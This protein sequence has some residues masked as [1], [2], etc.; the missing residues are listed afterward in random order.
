MK[1]TTVIILILV[2]LISCQGNSTSDKSEKT[3]VLAH[4]DTCVFSSTSWQVTDSI[5]WD[6]WDLWHVRDSMLT[7]ML[8]HHV[9]KGMTKEQII[10]ILGVPDP[11]PSTLARFSESLEVGS[12]S[13]FDNPY[14]DTILKL[15]KDTAI[16]MLAYRR[17][18]SG[19]GPNILGISLDKDNRA[20][21]FFKSRAE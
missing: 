11:W 13:M 18:F 5:K 15:G 14:R 10:G 7:D 3:K 16:E 8:N 19:S 21:E 4:A 6:N 12:Y 9:K 20:I 1:K 2:S 17:G